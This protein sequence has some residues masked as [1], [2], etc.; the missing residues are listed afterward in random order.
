M[1]TFLGKSESCMMTAMS[2]A[3]DE[4][5]FIGNSVLLKINEEN[6]KNTDIYILVEI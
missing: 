2:G 4:S 1:E 3:F 6:N 5:V